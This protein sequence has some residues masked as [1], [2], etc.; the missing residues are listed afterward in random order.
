MRHSRTMPQ[1]KEKMN[2]NETGKLIVSM[3]SAEIKLDNQVKKVLMNRTGNGKLQTLC[4]ERRFEKSEASFC[5][6]KSI[7]VR[8]LSTCT[9]E[10]FVYNRNIKYRDK[11]RYKDRYE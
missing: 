9:F 1:R 2:V 5:M 8:H 7:K 4:Q 11:D 3:S 6:E 10:I